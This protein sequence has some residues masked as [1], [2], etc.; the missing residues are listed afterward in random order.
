MITMD[1]YFKEWTAEKMSFS[2]G[3]YL[4]HDKMPINIVAR[5]TKELLEAAKLAGKNRVALFTEDNV[6]TLEEYKNDIDGQMLST[7]R[8]FFDSQ[9]S[10]GKN[11]IYNLLT[12]IRER[13]EEDR[14]SFARLT[15]FL[16][17]LE[18][19]TSKEEKSNFTK[20]KRSMI[21]WFNTKVEIRKAEQSLMLYVY[22]TRED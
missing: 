5:R 11:F 9:A 22:E 2:A 6:F 10:H 20:F 16:S 3:V 17:R 1:N 8:R 19:Q 13:S 15:Y 18:E 12:L 4:Y 21:D 14:I 7:I